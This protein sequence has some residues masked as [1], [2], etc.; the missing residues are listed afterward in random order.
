RTS[1]SLSLALSA[2]IVLG[3]SMLADA[4]PRER[5]RGASAYGATTARPAAASCGGGYSCNPQTRAL[6]QLA[7][8]Y[9]AGLV[10]GRTIGTISGR[11]VRTGTVV[12]R[13]RRFCEYEDKAE[14]THDRDHGA[15]HSRLLL[16]CR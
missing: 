6:E 13:R 7:D 3:L 12:L 5:Y 9:R 8:R 4:A 2:A 14:Q 15:R 16:V 1:M 10:S 11:P